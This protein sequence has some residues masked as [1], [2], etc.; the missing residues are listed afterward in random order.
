MSFITV[1]LEQIIL[2]LYKIIGNFGLS[3]IGITVLI[4]LLLLPLTLKQDKSM[5]AMKRIQPE[6]DKIKEKYKNDKQL[7]NEKTMELYQK[8]KVN[9]AAGCLPMLVQLPILWALFAVLRKA[10]VDGGIV[11]VESTFLWLTLVNPD[12]LYILPVLNGLV[13]FAQQKIMGSGS[14][15]QMKN[16]MYMF[17]IMMVFISYK[18]PAGLQIYW[19]TSSAAGILQQ[20]YVMKRGDEA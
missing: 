20:Y 3:I 17:P 6:I 11:P 15:P 4:K 18:M 16:M 1:P 13:A 7:L 14:N 12:P 10:P 2:Y 19:L 5:K 8:Y 9:P